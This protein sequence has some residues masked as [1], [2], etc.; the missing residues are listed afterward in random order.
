[1]IEESSDWSATTVYTS[2]GVSEAADTLVRRIGQLVE[3]TEQLSRA[4]LP[5]ATIQPRYRPLTLEQAAR[6]AVQNATK[7][8]ANR[9]RAAEQEAALDARLSPWLDDE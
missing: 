1:M 9:V 7:I 3:E 5:V 8:M 4:V 2:L 6:L